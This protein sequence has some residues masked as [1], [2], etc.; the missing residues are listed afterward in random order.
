MRFELSEGKHQRFLGDKNSFGRSRANYFASSAIVFST[1]LTT[2][3]K[4]S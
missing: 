3:A 4:R 2:S 1:P